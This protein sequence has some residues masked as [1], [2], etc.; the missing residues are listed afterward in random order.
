PGLWDMNVEDANRLA[1]EIVRRRQRQSRDNAS[2]RKNEADEQ[3]PHGRRSC[4]PQK[5]RRICEGVHDA[6]AYALP[7]RRCA[8]AS[9]TAAGSLPL[10]WL[11]AQICSSR[12]GM[13]SIRCR[14][15]LA[16]PSPRYS[17]QTLMIPPA[18]IT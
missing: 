5:P 11:S 8:I 14:T 1:L 16:S 7:M 4:D 9:A 12:T 10:A 13:P 15:R 17:V 6:A 3:Q 2:G 18:L